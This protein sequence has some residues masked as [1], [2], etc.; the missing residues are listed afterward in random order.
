MM[1]VPRGRLAVTM[2][3]ITDAM[4][5]VGQHGV[6]CQSQRWPGKPD[7]EFDGRERVDS[8]RDGETE[9]SLTK[10][11]AVA[12]AREAFSARPQ[13]VDYAI[14]QSAL[15]S[16]PVEKNQLYLRRQPRSPAPAHQGRVRRP[17]LPGPALQQPPGLQR[18]PRRKRR[19][20]LQLPELWPARIPGSGT[21]TP[22]APWK[23]VDIQSAAGFVT[24]DI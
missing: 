19:H 10:C 12:L 2:D 9:N 20:P 22:S 14:T 11:G 13:T 24:T 4:A 3:M 7:E 16:S 18:A 21:W 6:Y 1:G 17:H 5:L 8:E 15:E 23:R